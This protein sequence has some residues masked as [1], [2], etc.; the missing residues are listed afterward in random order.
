MHATTALRF[1]RIEM[2]VCHA[3]RV[4]NVLVLSD[5]FSPAEI[6]QFR[7]CRTDAHARHLTEQHVKPAAGDRQAAVRH[8]QQD[9]FP[10]DAAEKILRANR[11]DDFA[12]ERDKNS[13]ADRRPYLSLISFEVVKINDHKWMVAKI[14]MVFVLWLHVQSITNLCL[15]FG[16]GSPCKSCLT[17][18]V[19]IGSP[20]IFNKLQKGIR[21]HAHYMPRLCSRL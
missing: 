19:L 21:T 17:T 9:F 1:C 8:E 7:M 10:T 2:P 5:F 20:L 11:A 15:N 6:S 18:T 13:I 16:L 14:L 12:A 4:V 3:D